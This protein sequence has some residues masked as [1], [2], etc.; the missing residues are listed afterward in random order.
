[1]PASFVFN[2]DLRN[3]KQ[4]RR[5]ITDAAVSI[6]ARNEI[7]D[8]IVYAANELISNAITYGYG[9]NVGPIWV[10]IWRD[11]S[12]LYVRICDAAPAFNPLNVPLPRNLIGRGRQRVGGLGL[13]LSRH[14]LDDLQYREL[15]DGGNELILIKW[16][17]F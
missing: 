5:S 4:I 7:I 14:L 10:D 8:D 13:F 15:P 6:G 16:D 3:L 11:D 2:A 12:T 1:M 17:A 9:G